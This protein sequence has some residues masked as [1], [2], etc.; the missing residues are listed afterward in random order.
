M[1]VTSTRRPTPSSPFALAM[2]I[3][4]CPSYIPFSRYVAGSSQGLA[5]ASYLENEG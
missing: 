4:G 3:R 5:C 2:M 1:P